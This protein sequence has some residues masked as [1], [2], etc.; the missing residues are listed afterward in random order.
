MAAKRQQTTGQYLAMCRR[1]IR[2]AGRR[3]AWEDP[4]HLRE[5]AELKAAVD[6][7][8]AVAVAGQRAAGIT[9]DSIG[10]AMGYTR[11][12]AIKRWLH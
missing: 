4:E 5:L 1:M 7:A 12:A 9:W 10:E 11:Q 6:D 3:V 2:A 8:L